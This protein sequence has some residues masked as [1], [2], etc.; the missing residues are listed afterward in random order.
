MEARKGQGKQ[1][2]WKIKRK[3]FYKKGG[4]SIRGVERR[5]VGREMIE[6]IRE[7]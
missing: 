2:R 1:N 3:E 6:R 4:I 5:T 7:V